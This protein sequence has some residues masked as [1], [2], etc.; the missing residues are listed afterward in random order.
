MAVCIL[1]R[2]T[3][4]TRPRFYRVEIAYNLFEEISVLREWGYAGGQGQS[5][6]DIYG[7]LR[8][9]SVAADRLRNRALKRGY[10]RADRMLANS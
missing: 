4:A 9:A 10:S 7:N 8:E 1:Y 6:V 2:R 5:Q 3:R